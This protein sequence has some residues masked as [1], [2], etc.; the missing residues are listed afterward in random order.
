MSA[1]AKRF[2]VRHFDNNQ[3]CEDWL[4]GLSRA[5]TL[6]GMSDTNAYVTVIVEYMGR[7]DQALPRG[8]ELER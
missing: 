2:I 7:I 5:W 3:A 1:E 8:G 4:N 6:K